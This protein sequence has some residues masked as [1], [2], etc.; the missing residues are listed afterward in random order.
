M[1]YWPFLSGRARRAGHR[2]V[3]R[4]DLLD[5]DDAQEV[6]GALPA[7]GGG[8]PSAP[9]KVL[10]QVVHRSAVGPL[11][12]FYRVLEATA[13]GW[14]D[15]GR[16]KL[17]DQHGR[18]ILVTE[19]IVVRGVYPADG[20]SRAGLASALRRTRE[21]A[22]PVFREFWAMDEAFTPVALPAQEFPAE[23]GG[24]GPA[25]AD[26]EIVEMTR[27][28]PEP[29]ATG[30]VIPP[31]RM[32]RWLVPLLVVIMGLVAGVAGWTWWPH[33]CG[34]ISSGMRLNDEQ[35][36]ECIGVTD[37]SFLFTE[38]G[39]G[40]WSGEDRRIIAGINDVQR[41]IE[42]ANQQA[43]ETENYVKVVLLMPLTVSRTAPSAISLERILH[44]LQG[45][46][47]A[48][49]R[50]NQDSGRPGATMPSVQL[51]LANQGSRH[52][53]GTEFLDGV[54]GVSEPDHP[55]LAVVGLGSSV[56][57]TRTVAEYLAARGIPMVSAMTSADD[58][59]TLPLLWSVSP[60]NRD[61]ARALRSYLDHQNVLASGVIVYDQ[62]PDLYTRSLAEA[63]RTE[64]GRYLDFPAQPF[65][66]STLDSRS[67][68]NVFA[69]V[70]ANLCNAANDPDAPL[71]MVFYAGRIVDFGAFTDAL[72]G[73]AR[74][75]EKRR[76]TI[77][78]TDTTVAEVRDHT[79]ALRNANVGVV[80]AT[81]SDF[82]AWRRNEAGTPPGFPAFLRAFRES[83]FDDANLADGYAIA[84]HDALLTAAHAVEL[85]AREKPGHR[86]TRQ[87]VLSRLGHLGPDRAVPGASGQLTFPPD[88]GRAD[89]RT[90]RVQEI[91]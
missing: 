66:G 6:V 75:C 31:R 41:K 53:A 23:A 91:R 70:V 20:V 30:D 34:G 63:Y 10:R 1:R 76:L 15:T 25:L 74:T 68:A 19:G 73:A 27:S 32:R 65:Q 79:A 12:V 50:A 49:V 2:V 35:N 45:S 54:V 29:G 22:V 85:A 81:S 33:E 14:G 28:L 83:G 56:P 57:N 21:L 16:H 78:T 61:Y 17:H 88:G 26:V 82:T 3:V 43:A 24:A 4:P 7:P 60:S 52:E 39:N 86:P 8:F 51:L 5:V 9:G 11:T 72:D 62:N 69:P 38:P 80:Y 64:L 46:Y 90:I 89:G 36:R 40:S 42:K 71:D 47:A 58:L 48:L 37:G 67:A 18:P 13:D 44:S 84:H 87:D 77:L 59:S 55:L